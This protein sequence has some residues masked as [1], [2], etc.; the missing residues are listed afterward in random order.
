MNIDT[1][2][3]TGAKK[4]V[5]IEN[6]M[7]TSTSTLGLTRF[8]SSENSGGARKASSWWENFK[9]RVHE[10]NEDRLPGYQEDV[11][12][13]VTTDGFAEQTGALAIGYAVVMATVDT[14]RG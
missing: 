11:G 8:N 5:D 7:N 13:S 6:D 14:I 4:A 3:I 9:N 1:V 12:T 2:E 10:Y